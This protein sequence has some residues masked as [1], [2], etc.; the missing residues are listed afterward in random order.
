MTRAWSDTLRVAERHRLTLAMDG[1][2]FPAGCAPT[3][4]DEAPRE[5]EII[6]LANAIMAGHE[7]SDRLSEL[8]EQ[9]RSRP[10]LARRRARI[11]ELVRDSWD[12]RAALAALQATT[13]AGR[14]AKARVVREFTNAWNGCSAY[15]DEALA[16]SLAGDLLGLPSV[17]KE[18]DDGEEKQDEAADREAI[19]A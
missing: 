2:A 12:M 8:E 17:F 10:E 9:T 7:E 6:R 19:S 15:T 18:G 5:A 13:P 4:D 16:W 1:N 14:R 11:R 3:Q